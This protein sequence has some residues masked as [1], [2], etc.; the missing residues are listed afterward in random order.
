MRRATQRPCSA[1]AFAEQEKN[2]RYD[3]DEKDDRDDVAHGGLDPLWTFR[4]TASLPIRDGVLS[5]RHHR[6][7]SEATASLP[8]TVAVE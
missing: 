3:D 7:F 6:N 4:I 1:G 2:Q 8:L 5:A